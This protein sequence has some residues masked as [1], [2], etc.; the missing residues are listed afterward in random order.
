M[1]FRSPESDDGTR[2]FQLVERQGP[3][4]EASTTRFGFEA[5]DWEPLDMTFYLWRRHVYVPWPPPLVDEKRSCACPEYGE[6]M[7]YHRLEGD[8]E[9]RERVEQT[10]ESIRRSN[11]HECEADSKEEWEAFLRICRNAPYARNGYDFDDETLDAHFYGGHDPTDTQPGTAGPGM[12][13]PIGPMPAAHNWGAAGEY[14]YV[15]L[16]KNPDFSSSHL[17]RADHAYVALIQAME[18]YLD[19][20]S[21][22]ELPGD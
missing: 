1:L 6:G 20:H 22:D 9:K 7:S 3:D 17:T 16:R 14:R 13:L 4:D 19:E 11:V 10:F 18:S 8:D 2:P 21:I 15:G 5:R 12:S